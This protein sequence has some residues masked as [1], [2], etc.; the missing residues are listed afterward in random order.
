MGSPHKQLQDN[1]QLTQPHQI[2]VATPE[3]CTKGGSASGLIW[4]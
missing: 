1:G 2:Q 4:G 3:N